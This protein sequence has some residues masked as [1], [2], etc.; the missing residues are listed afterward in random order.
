[1]NGWAELK[2]AFGA[3]VDGGPGERD[4]RKAEL[5]AIDPA[6]PEMLDALLEADARGDAVLPLV[7]PA[8]PG[9]VGNYEVIGMLGA[10]AMGEVY[11]ARDPRLGRDV[12]IKVLHVTSI[13]DPDRLARFE[14]EA[15][16]LASL[17]HPRV[18]HVYGL[19]SVGGSPAL[20]M[21]LV[22]GPTL[23]EVTAR[24]ADRRMPVSDAVRLAAQIA[25]GL[26][27]AHE[28]GIIHRDLKPSNIAL[29]ADG[30]IKV[31]DFGIAKRLADPESA[32][33]PGQT[34]AGAMLGTPAY[35][36]PELARGDA[37]DQRAD[38]WAFG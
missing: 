29:T 1:V 10:G 38:L 13:G 7:D 11:R 30:N 8:G 2:A 20:V 26:S 9:R 18:A 14:R 35:M 3:I 32:G 37:C 19:E 21:E 31:L 25:D 22:E 17:N 34:L 33:T 5:R 27:A 4:R 23:A 36:S 24:Q 28:R 16:V 15:R 12:A 6:L